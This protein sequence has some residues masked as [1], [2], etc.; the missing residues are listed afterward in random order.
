MKYRRMLL[1]ACVSVAGMALASAPV[2]AS[3]IGYHANPNASIEGQCHGAFGAFSH[4]G[5]YSS[6]IPSVDA[7]ADK[8]AGTN[9]GGNVYNP[10]AEQRGTCG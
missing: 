8:A 10:N 2:L 1:A 4:N 7:H 3:D 9:G 6:F 5:V